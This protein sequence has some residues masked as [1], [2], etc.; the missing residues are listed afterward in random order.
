MSDTDRHAGEAAPAGQGSARVERWS[1]RL[2]IFLFFALIAA[3]FLALLLAAA[4]YVG[5]GAPDHLVDRLALAG[6]CATF[7]ALGLVTWVWLKSD[8]HVAK[9][10]ERLGA[11][12]SAAVHAGMERPVEDERARYLGLIAPA[13]R[14]ASQALAA[15]RHDVE[16]RVRQ[17]TAEAERQKGRLEAVLRDLQ[18]G[19]V[20]ATLDHRILLYNTFARRLLETA[21]PAPACG[22]GRALTDLLVAQPI[23]HA[24]DRLTRRFAWRTPSEF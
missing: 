14:E 15:A 17:A 4:F 9:P 2:R 24:L 8:D 7:A 19:V 21:R 13:L 11:E 22:L 18:Q 12:L 6:L 1:L 10:L 3:G 16:E 20:I 23:R 5:Q